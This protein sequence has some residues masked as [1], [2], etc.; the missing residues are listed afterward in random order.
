VACY[1]FSQQGFNKEKPHILEVPDMN[2]GEYTSSVYI[3]RE[4]TALQASHA[5]FKDKDIGPRPELLNKGLPETDLVW[6][7][8]SSMPEATASNA[9]K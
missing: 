2:K 9:H 6:T 4:Y 5:Y 8:I 3:K 7:M 1:S